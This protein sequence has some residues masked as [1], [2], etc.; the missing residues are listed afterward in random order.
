MQWSISRTTLPS[1]QSHLMECTGNSVLQRN[2]PKLRG[3]K[4][5]VINISI[6]SGRASSS[7][8]EEKTKAQRDKG[9]YPRPHS[10]LIMKVRLQP[11]AF[12]F[13]SEFSP[14]LHLLL[15]YVGWLKEN[16]EPCPVLSQNKEGRASMWG[17]GKQGLLP[18][19]LRAPFT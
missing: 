9:T 10:S 18:S 1:Y 11:R 5:H 19:I 3:F 16:S 8:T 12:G 4:H 6:N 2:H 7:F 14:L 17:G 13:L 15:Q